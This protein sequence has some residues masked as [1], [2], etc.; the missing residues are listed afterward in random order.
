MINPQHASTVKSPDVVLDTPPFPS[1][2]QTRLAAHSARDITQKPLRRCR[3]RTASSN[4]MKNTVVQ[5]KMLYTTG[6]TIKNASKYQNNALICGD[7]AGLNVL[8]V[9]SPA[10]T[11][12]LDV[13][14]LEMCETLQQDLYCVWTSGERVRLYSRTNTALDLRRVRLYSRTYTG[15]QESEALQ[16]DIYC[17][18]TSGDE[19]L[20]QD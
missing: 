19:A 5:K 1:L 15:P 17:V 16:Q 13:Q 9:R 12:Q 4:R 10:S 8:K 14:T 3:S 11:A 6:E 20:Q 18:W 2:H 7:V